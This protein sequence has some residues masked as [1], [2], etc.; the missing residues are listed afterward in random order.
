MAVWTLTRKEWLLLLRER[1]VV[2]WLLV[3]PMVF[4][5]VFGAVFSHLSGTGITVPYVNLDGTK[6]AQAFLDAVKKT[7]GL[8][9][10]Q[11]P[12]SA[13]ADQ[14]ARVAAGRQSLLLVVPQGFGRALAHGTA[15]VA[16]YRAAGSDQSTGPVLAAVEQ[17]ANTYRMQAVAKTLA[18]HGLPMPAV[19]KVLAGPVRVEDVEVNA[20]TYDA[21]A[22]IV[23]GYTVMFAFYTIISIVRR[24]HLDKD[25][26]MTARLMTTRLRPWQYLAGAWLPYGMAVCVQ[27]AVLLAFG[28]LLY[29]VHLGDVLAIAVLVAAVALCVTSMGLAV[30]VWVKSENQGNAWTQL[31]A[32][33]GAMVGGLW[34]PIDMMPHTIQ[35]IG[36]L[37]PQYWA[38]QGMQT[39]MLRA[40]HVAAIWQNVAV[41]AAFSAAAFA[42]AAWRFPR[43]L[44]GAVSG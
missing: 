2:F 29:G 20:Q 37:T 42:L 15:K 5:L 6:A 28:R 23:P 4:I 24:F 31:F 9:L 40:G 36:H 44:R 38:Q 1:G 13:L 18:A 26:G 11:E 35:I 3:L 19:A 34:F 7:G 8:T 16:L 21:L 33:G 32:L 12:A 43:F 14:K 25:L 39:V 27:C 41:L 22:Q 10:S 17:A 30:A